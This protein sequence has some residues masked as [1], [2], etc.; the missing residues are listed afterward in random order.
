MNEVDAM[1]QPRPGWG[2][3]YRAQF[4]TSVTCWQEEAPSLVRKGKWDHL[5]LPFSAKKSLLHKY[6][7]QLPTKSL[8]EWYM[9]EERKLMKVSVPKKREAVVSHSQKFETVLCRFLAMAGYAVTKREKKKKKKGPV[10]NFMLMH[11]HKAHTV[12]TD[13]SVLCSWEAECF[14]FSSINLVPDWPES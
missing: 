3:K 7:W 14:L 5:P 2:I 10:P 9:G 13:S 12:T 8:R 11:Q 4:C 1:L 6:I